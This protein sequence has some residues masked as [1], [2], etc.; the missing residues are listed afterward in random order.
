MRT[1]N[2]WNT[3]PTTIILERFIE[4][5]TFLK[6]FRDDDTSAGQE[7]RDEYQEQSD[8]L[9]EVINNRHKM[10]NG[11]QGFMMGKTFLDFKGGA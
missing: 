7:L 4:A 10:V 9:L 8:I 5:Q 1:Y 6:N 2:D 3:Q 11:G